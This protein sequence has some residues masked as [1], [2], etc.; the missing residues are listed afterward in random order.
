MNP[1]DKQTEIELNE[2]NSDEEFAAFMLNHNSDTD[3]KENIKN[4]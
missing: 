2:I 4:D 3:V 1:S